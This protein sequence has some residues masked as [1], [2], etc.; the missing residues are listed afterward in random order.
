MD[1]LY[2][3]VASLLEYDPQS[4]G[5]T[6]TNCKDVL[7]RL[8]GKPAGCTY[9]DW[10]VYI[11]HGG[12]RLLAHRIAWV[13]LHGALPDSHIDH[14]NMNRSDNRRDNLR[15]ATLSENNRNRAKQS[16][17]TSGYKGVT[18]H[19][20]TGKYQ[21]KICINKRRISLGYFD[22]PSIAS[23]AYQ[24]AAKEHHGEFAR[25]K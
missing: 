17:N 19:C 5:F 25:H 18:F 22:D 2:K 10:Y 9:L 1:E 8:R 20:R 6:W 21:A 15:H 14:I 12:R 24:Q 16:N 23:E 13:K 7:T 4:G 3:Y 11:R